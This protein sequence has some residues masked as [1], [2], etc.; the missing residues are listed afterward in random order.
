[1]GRLGRTAWLGARAAVVAMLAVAA[2]VLAGCGSPTY[3]YV[4]SPDD[5]VVF[6]LPRA[7]TSLD[8][9]KVIPAG[10]QPGQEVSWL[11]F[12]D[13]AK[14][15]DAAHAR[16]AGAADPVVMAETYT[17][18]KDEA[19]AV[20][21][22]QLRNAFGP[23]TADAQAQSKISRAAQG[24][25]ELQLRL[26]KDEQFH[27]RLAEGVHVVF[28]VGQGQDEVIYDQVGVIDRKTAQ[29]HFLVVS[30]LGDCYRAKQAQIE[31]VARSFTV[32]HP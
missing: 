28:A 17:L 4:S 23:I 20:T 31:A 16:M 29:A 25:P 15:P 22:D 10:S 26:I 13:G 3:R 30:C 18:S 8:L 2:V 32:K 1:M 5:G 21:D 7:W 24:L 9:A 14:R 12:F 19:A 11:A 27:S 6:L